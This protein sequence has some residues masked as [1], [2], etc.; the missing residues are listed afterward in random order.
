[1]LTNFLLVLLLTACV[2]CK[3][4]KNVPSAQ[5]STPLSIGPFGNCYAHDRPLIGHCVPYR[6]CISALQ[7][8]DDV[9]VL[10]CPSE[11]KKHDRYVCCPHGGYI[12]PEPKQSKSER[13]CRKAY[14]RESH[15]RRRRQ[16]DD[17]LEA[18]EAPIRRLNF[19]GTEV[20]GGRLTQPD[21]HPYMCALGWRSNNKGK[22]K[23]N[24]KKIDRC[25][26]FNCGC[27]LIERKF[28]LTAA[29]CA[30]LGGESP[31]IVLIGGVDLNSTET[32]QIIRIKEIKIH[33]NY[34]DESNYNDLAII[35]L[36]KKSHQ[37]IACLWANDAVPEVPLTAMG[38][39]QTRFAG[40]P[41]HRLLQVQLYP[42][43]N[44]QCAGYLRDADKLKNGLGPGQLCAGDYSGRMD[45]CQGD[46]GGPL[47]MYQ[48]D[49]QHRLPYVI[50]ITSLGGICAS[51]APGVYT[52]I[53]HYIPWIERKVW[54]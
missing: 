34:D 51:G 18:I 30:S 23:G 1:M 48:Q 26:I 25:Y 28:A 45:T 24:G 8:R 32:S 50:G 49:G 47:V 33:P 42:L 5:P 20:V 16:S 52:R 10:E 35:K 41:S 27:V 29:H 6:D 17:Q 7:A 3:K 36:E 14:V 13:A 4:H 43:N 38:Y 15:K 22:G 19:S 31:E 46:S 12:V 37:P 9:T 54:K 44:Q 40:P 2:S 39:G 21:E 53:S 11:S